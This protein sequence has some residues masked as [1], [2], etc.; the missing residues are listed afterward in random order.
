VS[1]Y[2]GNTWSLVQEDGTRQEYF[3]SFMKE[4][5][6]LLESKPNLQDMAQYVRD[7]GVERS[8]DLEV[9]EVRLTLV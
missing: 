8:I 3:G 2:G 1:P 5:L 4:Y 6:A 9:V 7:H